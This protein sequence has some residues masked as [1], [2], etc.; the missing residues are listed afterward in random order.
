MAAGRRLGLHLQRHLYPRPFIRPIMS[1]D[2]GSIL[3]LRVSRLSSEVQATNVGDLSS[4]AA[5]QL[6]HTA[7]T[8]ADSTA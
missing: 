5:T 7:D 4:A 3:K 6:D 1:T 8:T 2:K